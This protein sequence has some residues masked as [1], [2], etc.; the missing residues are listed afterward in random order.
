MSAACLQKITFS[1]RTSVSLAAARTLVSS[2]EDLGP[3][4]HR[5]RQADAEDVAEQVEETPL[6]EALLEPQPR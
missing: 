5:A 1:N 3:Q 2:W 4:A 6:R